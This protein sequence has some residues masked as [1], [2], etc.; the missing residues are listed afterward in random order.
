MPGWRSKIIRTVSEAEG[1]PGAALPV[2]AGQKA[3]LRAVP[4]PQDA[5]QGGFGYLCDG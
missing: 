5:P 1:R 4:L 2:P 3:L